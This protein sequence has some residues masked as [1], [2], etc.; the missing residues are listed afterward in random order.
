MPKFF[1]TAKNI[2][3]GERSGGE[4]ESR[5]ERTLAQELRAQGVLLTSHKEIEEATTLHI[6]FFDR[7]SSVPLM[8]TALMVT[9]GLPR[10]RVR[11]VDPDHQNGRFCHL[12]THTPIE[13]GGLGA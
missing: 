3:T 7:F 10:A 8:T 12:L 1:Y 2:T 4:I 6:K 5:D 11:H 9:E 13:G